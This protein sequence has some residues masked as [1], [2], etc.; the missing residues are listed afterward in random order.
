MVGAALFSA[1]W[2]VIDAEPKPDKPATPAVER[3]VARRVVHA[4]EGAW[5]PTTNVE[6][7]SGLRRARSALLLMV[8]LTVLGVFAALI[9]VVGGAVLLSALRSAVQ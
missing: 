5:G 6:R 8:I 9:I 1:I 3:V 7:V 4:T 2:V